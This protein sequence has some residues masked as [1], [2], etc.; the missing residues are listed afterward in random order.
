MIEQT[1]N[2]PVTSHSEE[3]AFS[4]PGELRSDLTMRPSFRLAFGMQAIAILLDAIAVFVTFWISYELRYTYRIGAIVPVSRDTLGFSQWAQHALVAIVFTI[5]VFAARGV[6]QVRRKIG[7]VDYIPLVTTSYGLAIAGVI[8][9]A[10]FIQF[11]PSRAIYLFALVIGTTLMLGHRALA[12]LIRRRMFLRGMGVDRAVIVGSSENARRLMQSLLGQPQWG[13]Q[14][15]GFV[16]DASITSINVATER[17]I[18]SAEK[19]G[20]IPELARIVQQFHIDDVFIVEADHAGD[21]IEDMVQSCR[22]IG[23]QFRLVPDLLQISMDRVDIADINGVPL[24]GIRDAS[25]RGWSAITKRAFDIVLAG[26]LLVL[27]MIPTAILVVL[28]RRDSE[29]SAFYRQTRIGQYLKPFEIVKFRTMYQD[30]DQRRA[31]IVQDSGVDTR[32]FKDENDP[33]ITKIG[34]V[35][36]KYSIDELPQ[37]WN[38]FKGDMTFV[39]P[40]PPLPQEVADYQPWH[41]QRLLVRPGM[42]GLWQVNGRSNLSFDQMVR[43]D[44]Y[45]AEN[46][47]L[48]LDAKILLRT[49]PAVLFS[50]GAY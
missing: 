35:L 34:R 44:L 32:L 49:I 33:R 9:F 38:V 26:T 11:S 14:L 47:S 36:R 1:Q 46:W 19:L 17:G 40:R 28:V 41:Q 20:S 4:L 5:L 8:L 45:Y 16:T 42:T 18:R 3:I 37:I 23:A 39:G 48:W 43:L 7:W 31:Q 2:T 6:Y 25:I 10:F 30:A 50:R 12:H 27:M 21:E 24:I 13:Y 15:L 22:S 29:G